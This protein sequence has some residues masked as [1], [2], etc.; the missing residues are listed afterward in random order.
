MD[1]RVLGGSVAGF[2]HVEH[3]LGCDDAH[4]WRVEA[5]RMV[6]AVADGAGSRTGTS[7][8]GAHVAV[9]SV[10]DG[11]GEACALEQRFARALAAVEAE[12]ARL[13]LE[14]SRLATTLCV[15]VLEPG[16]ASVGQIGDGIAVI[17]TEAGIEAVARAERFEYANE[18]VFL[19]SRDALAHLS[20]HETE[21]EL[22]AVALSTDGLRYKILDDL[23]TGRPYE[24]FFAQSWAYA[25]TAGATSASIDR[26][27]DGVDDQTGDDKTLLLAVAGC[28]GEPHGLSPRPAPPA[29]ETEPA[30]TAS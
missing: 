11:A 14:P 26:F 6:L 28:A 5:E 13:E 10:L 23:A 16:R 9:A 4:G 24:P 1:W 12:A 3:G 8:I 19:T 18:T 25:R 22:L 21:A 29:A 20:A 27:L 15:A 7:A 17:E 30:E 2:L